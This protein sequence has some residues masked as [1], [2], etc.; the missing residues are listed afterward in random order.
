MLLQDLNNAWWYCLLALRRLEDEQIVFFE[1]FNFLEQAFLSLIK[2]LWEE[3]EWAFF[4]DIGK[5]NLFRIL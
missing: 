4:R 2:F 3:I 1:K 5:D